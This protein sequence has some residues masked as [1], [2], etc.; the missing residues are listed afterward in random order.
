LRG[1][2]QLLDAALQKLLIGAKVRQ[3]I[4]ARDR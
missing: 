3:F 4:G 2:S 1:L